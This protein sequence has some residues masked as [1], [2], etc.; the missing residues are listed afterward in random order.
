M[1]PPGR[2]GRPTHTVAKQGRRLELLAEGHTDGDVQRFSVMDSMGPGDATSATCS[3][4]GFSCLLSLCSAADSSAADSNHFDVRDLQGAEDCQGERVATR[5]RC[6]T[7][8]RMATRLS[9]TS[10]VGIAL[11]TR[12]AR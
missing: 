5:Q 9:L 4:P 8:L 3:P 2:C 7:Y 6:Q 10:S 11:H 1:T 12:I